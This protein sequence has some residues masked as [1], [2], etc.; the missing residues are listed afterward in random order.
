MHK[1]KQPAL[2]DAVLSDDLAEVQACLTRG[3]DANGVGRQ[4]RTGLH[5][6][7][8][9]GNHAIARLL[10]AAGADVDARD[11]GRWTPLHFAARAQDVALAEVLVAAG[12]HVDAQNEHGN[13]PLFCAVS[14]SQGEGGMIQFLLGRGAD[15]GIK[16]LHG[17]SALEFAERIAN[18]DVK[19]WFA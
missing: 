13:T 1:R 3:A 7:A 19:R 2:M 10:I 8:T 12:A 6:A 11:D 16:N 18:Y 17:V 15:R 9:F 4:G 5:V 14:T